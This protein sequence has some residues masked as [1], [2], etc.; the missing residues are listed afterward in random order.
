MKQHVK[1]YYERWKER[2][3]RSPY[4]GN[5]LKVGSLPPKDQDRYRPFE[6]RKDKDGEEEED[7]VPDRFDIENKFVFDFYISVPMSWETIGEYFEATDL[8]PA[9]IDS[10]CV[11]DMFPKDDRV[12]K[13]KGVPVTAVR[14]YF[15]LKPD[16][17]NK[18]DA[19]FQD[20]PDMESPE[21]IFDFLRFN[22]FKIFAID[23]DDC[24][25]HITIVND[26]PDDDGF[27]VTRKDDASGVLEVFNTIFG[28]TSILS[29]LANVDRD[30]EDDRKIEPEEKD[31][32]VVEPRPDHAD[33]PEP[34]PVAKEP[35]PEEEKVE[36]KQD[37]INFQEL[38]AQQENMI[39]TLSDIQRTHF[40]IREL[41][42]NHTIGDFVKDNSIN[43]S[44]M[45]RY[46]SEYK[47]MYRDLLSAYTTVSDV[48]DRLDKNV[49]EL[50]KSTNVIRK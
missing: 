50:T 47:M 28:K 2:K 38:V 4:T 45:E 19:S 24:V 46:M 32:P 35:E 23:I 20:I 30:T 27:V 33:K 12:L 5:F 9:T 21:L 43:K 18:D 16:G 17:S 39:Q 3:V 25:D 37:V 48:L 6:F 10:G 13:L 42:K 11:V 41:L 22:E 14:K 40:N 15:D 44:N 36:A 7:D 26:T 8:I 34:K 29:E 49:N 31:T 1:E